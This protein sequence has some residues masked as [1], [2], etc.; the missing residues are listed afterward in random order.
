MTTPGEARTGLR[1]AAAAWFYWIGCGF[2]RDGRYWLGRAL[3]ADP[4]RSPDR[5]RALWTAGW[6]AFLQGEPA[7]ST[8]LLEQARDLAVDLG[9]GN[10]LT[11][12]TLFL[13]NTAVF[14]T[15][16]EKGLALLDEAR[17]RLR[18]SGQWTAPD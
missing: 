12:A 17:G 3:A 11:Y 7:A 8:A 5:A 2:I 13:G 10:A 9:D 16:P 15:S 6:I 14:G 1:L 4:G 18:R